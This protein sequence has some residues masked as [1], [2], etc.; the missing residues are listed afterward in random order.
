V[1]SLTIDPGSAKPG[2]ACVRGDD[3]E[4]V[5]AFFDYHPPGVGL[6][7]V[8]IERPQVDGR[9]EAFGPTST[10][11]LAW[12]GGIAAGFALAHGARLVTYTPTEWKGSEPKPLNHRRLWRVLSL[13]EKRVLGG[14]S[15]Q[16]EIENA[17]EKGALKRWKI[18]GAECYPRG[19]KTH[20]LLDAAA[21]HCVHFGRLAKKDLVG[22]R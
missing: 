5:A 19:S 16:R 4:V 8:I 7:F 14:A 21:L 9:T 13:D 11:N 2:P 6:D 3:G 12:D 20:N 10:V 17:V 18:S 22:W 1:K 15:T